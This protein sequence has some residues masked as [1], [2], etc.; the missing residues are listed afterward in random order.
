MIGIIIS[1]LQILMAV[2]IHL[3]SWGNYYSL[4]PDLRCTTQR[5]I[6]GAYY[7]AGGRL[8]FYAGR[9]VAISEVFLEIGLAS[10]YGEKATPMLRYRKGN[11]FIVPAY[12]EAKKESVYGVVLGWQF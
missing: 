4:H 3:N 5:T 11:V 7:N 6:T 1:C 8:S 12:Q 2:S 9:E 10:G